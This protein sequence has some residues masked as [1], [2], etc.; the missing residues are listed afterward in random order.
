MDSYFI[1][2][3]ATHSHLKMRLAEIRFDLRSTVRQTKEALERRFGSSADTM[4]L[5]L[6]DTAGNFLAAMS[7][8]QETLAHYGPQEGY[9]LH[10]VDSAPSTLLAQFEDVSQVEKY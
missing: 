9:T 3:D 6:R 1:K 8:D 10:V 4:N 7:N 5:E 2:L